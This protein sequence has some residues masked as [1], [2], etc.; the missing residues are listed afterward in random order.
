[1]LIGPL[2]QAALRTWMAAEQPQICTVLVQLLT[3]S[4]NIREVLAFPTQVR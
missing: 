4:H 1:M 3:N 2:L